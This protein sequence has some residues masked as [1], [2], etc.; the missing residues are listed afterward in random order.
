M[1]SNSQGGGEP[2]QWKVVHYANVGTGEEF[3]EYFACELPELLDATMIFEP[4]RSTVREAIL[5]VMMDGLLPAFE[6]LKTI[7]ASMGQSLP[8]LNRQ[9]LF[10]E[11]SGALWQSYKSLFPKAALA[12]GF[13]IGF[14]FQNDSNFEKGVLAFNAKYPPLAGLSDHLREQRTNW[15]SSLARFRNVMEH[16]VKDR[17]RFVEFYEPSH[18]EMLFD[19][20]WRT[21]ADL[22]PIFIAAH[23]SPSHTIAEIPVNQR[24]PAHRRRFRQVW[25]GPQ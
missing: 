23:F 1:A 19:S 10:E 13:D 8:I 6:H 11:F 24:D 22:L 3:V 14:L 25:V 18:A 9:Q 12:L 5:T 4:E 7:R 2:S 21:M 15:Q 17:V 16:R 20:A